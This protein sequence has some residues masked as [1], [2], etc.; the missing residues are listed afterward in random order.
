MTMNPHQ[1]PGND[2]LVRLLFKYL[3]FQTKSS[4]LNLTP[5]LF[6][7]DIP[8]SVDPDCASAICV[9]KSHRV[10]HTYKYLMV[11]VLSDCPSCTVHSLSLVVFQDSSHESFCRS[12]FRTCV[13]KTQYFSPQGG[14]R[15]I[16]EHKRSLHYFLMPSSS[17]WSLHGG[18]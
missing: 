12:T 1:R 9:L 11:F 10:T 15:N 14:S 18:T 6:S 8:S 7:S 2:S 4:V 17:S 5:P 13:C 3:T 16:T